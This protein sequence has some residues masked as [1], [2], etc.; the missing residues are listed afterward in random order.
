[1]VGK[2]VMLRLGEAASEYQAKQ[3]VQDVIDRALAVADALHQ[4]RKSNERP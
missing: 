2:P 1:M 4:L 3:Q